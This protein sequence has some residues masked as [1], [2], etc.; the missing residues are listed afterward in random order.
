MSTKFDSL[1]LYTK[2]KLKNG[3][4]VEIVDIDNHEGIVKY[5]VEYTD[6]T[7]RDGNTF[8]VRPI[9]IRGIAASNAK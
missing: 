1:P 8:W 5:M 2:V 9:A 3:K 7:N 4:L 6:H